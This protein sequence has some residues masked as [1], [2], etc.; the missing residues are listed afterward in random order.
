MRSN[1]EGQKR[2]GAAKP[3]A[4]ATATKKRRSSGVQ[5]AP[6]QGKNGKKLSGKTK[7]TIRTAMIT[8]MI[9]FAVVVVIIGGIVFNEFFIFYFTEKSPVMGVNTPNSRV[10]QTPVIENAKIQQGKDAILASGLP[11][12]NVEIRQVGPSIHFVL[13][14]NNDADVAKGREVGQNS[15]IIFADTIGTP[16]LFG[17]YDAQIIVTKTDLPTLDEAT[18]LRPAAEDGAEQP[19]P[20]FGVSNKGTNG[21]AK[22]ISWSRNAE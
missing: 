16:E 21:A 12:T 19:F 22:G 1:N 7:V 9:A 6:L 4:A 20:Q 3:K 10:A 13:T 8:L 14:V 2:R 5:K 15:I 11:L 17:T 18:L